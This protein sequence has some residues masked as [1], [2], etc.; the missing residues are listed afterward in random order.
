MPKKTMSSTATRKGAS[1]LRSNIEA[2]QRAF[3][4]KDVILARVD[5]CLGNA[6][7]RLKYTDG[8][9][10]RG[11]PLGKYTFSTLRIAPGQFVICDPGKLESVLTIVG[12]FD[13]RKDVNELVKLNRIPKAML[14][15][16]NDTP[17]FEDGFEFE[18]QEEDEDE[19]APS[20]GAK[21]HKLVDR[22]SK[23]TSR[24]T[25]G[26]QLQDEAEAVS[27]AHAE[28]DKVYLEQHPEL[29]TDARRRAKKAKAPVAP[30][31]PVAEAEAEAE[32]E[33]FQREVPDNWEED[34]MDAYIKA[35]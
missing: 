26:Q 31:A 25:A 8:K 22:Y 10:G 9:E 4:G 30:L 20:S 12:R 18:D 15:G 6:Q 34:E 17:C 3:E 7:F 5:A 14:N 27:L 32:P 13:R 23:K 1:A 19:A 28:L 35:I 29:A 21:V 2:I 11:T 24:V 16:D 33:E